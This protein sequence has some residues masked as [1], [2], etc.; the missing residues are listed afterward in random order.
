MPFFWSAA[1]TCRAVALLLRLL[2]VPRLVLSPLH[3]LERGGRV[4]GRGEVGS[5][6]VVLLTGFAGAPPCTRPRV[7]PRTLG[8]RSQGFHPLHPQ[9]RLV[10][11]LSGTPID[12]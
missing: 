6:P 4:S 8:T 10:V 1:L 3:L 12:A 7:L 9:L 5:R 11:P 2:A